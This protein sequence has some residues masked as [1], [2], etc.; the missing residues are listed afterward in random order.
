MITLLELQR[1][2]KAMVK[3]FGPGEVAYRRK[4]MALGLTP[5][6]S[7]VVSRFAPLG[8]PIEIIVRGASLSLRKKEA[9][10]MWVERVVA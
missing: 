9:Q 10:M 7:F 4:L 8:D 5:G 3:S 2:D 6:T 1:G